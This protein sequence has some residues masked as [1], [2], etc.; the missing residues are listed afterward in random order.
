LAAP[1]A[2]YKRPE[3]A[4]AAALSTRCRTSARRI[5]SPKLNYRPLLAPAAYFLL[6][7]FIPGI[8]SHFLFVKEPTD[9]YCVSQDKWF[10]R[11]DLST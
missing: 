10:A 11:A 8:V 6:K 2:W 5:A 3:T 4:A 7:C 9:A 1:A